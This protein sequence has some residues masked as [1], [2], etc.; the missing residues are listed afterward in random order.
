MKKIT[1][2]VLIIFSL[3]PV[4][5]FLG[6]PDVLVNGID[7]NFPLEPWAW[8]QRRFFVWSSIPNAGADFSSSTAGTFFHFIQT[9]PYVLGFKL[10]LVEIVSFVFWFSLIV[11]GS[12]ILARKFLKGHAFSQL[13]F[14]CLYS[15]NIFLFNTWENA[16]V[17]NLSLMAGLPLTIWLLISLKEKK[18]SFTKGAFFATLIGLVLSG[19]GINPAYFICVYLSLFIFW[20]TEV[21]VSKRFFLRT[22]EVLWV[23]LFIFLVN[24]FWILPTIQF[25]LGNISPLQSIDK[26][27]FN[28]WVDSLSENTS[29]FNVFRLQGAWDW[30]AFDGVTGLPLYIPY[31]LRYF[32]DPIFILF[33]ITLPL[34]TIVSLIFHSREKIQFYSA[35]ALMIV[36]GVFLGAGTHLPTGNIFRILLNKLPFF[37]LFRSPWYIFTP[38]LVLGASGLIS[39]GFYSLRKKRYIIN[40]AIVI[41]LIGNLFYS[42]PLVLGKIFRPGRHDTFYIKFPG[43][44]MDAGKWLSQTLSQ[45]RVIGY[46]DDEIEQFSWGYRGIESLLSLISDREVLFSP[47]NMPD[48]PVAK[49]VKLFYWHLK[50]QNIKSATNIASYLNIG[51]IFEKRDQDSLSFD[52]PQK[53]TELPKNS[54]GAWNF[55]ELPEQNPKFS[56]P[57]SMVFA[58]PYSDAADLMSYLSREHLVLNPDDT[59]V[60]GIGTF[61][62]YAG[63][64]VLVKSSQ[65]RSFREFINSPSRLSNRLTRRDPGRV[66]YIFEV[67]NDG[68]YEVSL[69]AYK[70]DEFGVL[71]NDLVK[72]T[73]NGEQV[74]LNVIRRDDSY[75]YFEPRFIKAGSYSWVLEIKNKNLI[76]DGFD[77]QGE[78]NISKTSEFIRIFNKNERDMGAQFAISDFDPTRGYLVEV[79]YKQIYG[80]NASLLFGQSTQNIL[81]KTQVERLPN[82]PDWQDFSV[83]Y[84]PVL[85][86]SELSVT[87]L[88]PSTPDPLG[89]EVQYADL[90][91]YKVFDNDLVLLRKG[92]ELNAPNVDYGQLSPV[93]YRGSINKA[94][95]GHVVTFLENYSPNWEFRILGKNPNILH[96]SSN[97]YSNSWFVDGV[98]GSYEFE[99][100]YKPQNYLK[101]GYMISISVFILLFIL[102]IREWR[103]KIKEK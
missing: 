70:L 55:Y 35:F 60:S 14:V 89:T 58:Y 22:K 45:G 6:K 68:V 4:L 52:L 17:A 7:T 80:N 75:I 65:K 97:L 103:K 26:I 49:L 28:S 99:V 18:I 96:F 69:E 34:L 33:S 62:N 81:V 42:Y 2:L 25:I 57:K 66:E 61:L 40:L 1:I 101:L 94:Q 56:A 98:E 51:Q 93:H 46:P 10:Q 92:K 50:R 67:K 48:A 44:V 76:R 59:I 77:Q 29:L 16:K 43:Y 85:T 87:L 23:S 8:F 39:L 15:F 41:L 9:A 24:L 84:G 30:Y 83:Y 19:A 3:V 63:D 5:W 32:F 20:I 86:E 53:I 82:H 31:A 100:Y 88:A 71:Q 74:S 64:I 90:A 13:L 102:F 36:L 73:I 27:G 78:G 79:R 47:L 72:I 54:F 21:I 95:G 12:F 11:F 38:L 37:T 91:A